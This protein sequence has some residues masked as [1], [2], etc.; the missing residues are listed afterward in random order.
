MRLSKAIARPLCPGQGDCAAAPL[1]KQSVKRLDH[2]AGNRT[3]RRDGLFKNADQ[4]KLRK[5]P[6]K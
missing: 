4:I 6:I 2:A 5:M 3:E 1:S